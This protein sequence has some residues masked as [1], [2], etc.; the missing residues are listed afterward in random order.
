MVSSTE[1]DNL[2]LIS[3]QTFFRDVID[4][5]LNLKMNFC[6][7]YSDFEHC[8]QWNPPVKNKITNV[9]SGN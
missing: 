9:Y 1:S 6:S 2:F 7:F 3:I 5:N 4:G 8:V